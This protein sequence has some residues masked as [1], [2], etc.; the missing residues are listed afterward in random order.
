MKRITESW[1]PTRNL[2]AVGSLALAWL[3]TWGIW[4]PH[5][6]AA[7]RQ[8]FYDFAEWATFLNEVRFGPLQEAPNYLRLGVALG[9]IALAWSAGELRMVWMRW[10]LR[11]FVLIS[12]V[13]LLPFYPGVFDLGLFSFWWANYRFQFIVAL[14]LLLALPL[15]LA[16]D[17]LPLRMRRPLLT[18]LAAAAFGVALWAYLPLR[19]VFAGHYAGNLPPG[20]GSLAFFSGL[21]IS[22]A[23]QL[24]AWWDSGQSAEM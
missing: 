20:W 3:A 9:L 10:L 1:D 18:G 4:V 23:A 8:N 13:L 6:A 24:Y 11:G 7:L 16:I 15:S 17:L 22:I 12:A 19:A 21:L 14:T 5:G 2:V